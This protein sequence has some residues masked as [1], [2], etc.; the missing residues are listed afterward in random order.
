MIVTACCQSISVVVYTKHSVH[1]QSLSLVNTAFQ[2]M[3]APLGSRLH[4]L[5]HAQRLFK[6]HHHHQP[7]SV[8]ITTWKWASLF[9]CGITDLHANVN[10]SPSLCYHSKLSFFFLSFL[11]SLSLFLSLLREEVQPASGPQHWDRVTV[12]CASPW[13]VG[14][15]VGVYVR[16]CGEGGVRRWTACR[17]FL[18]CPL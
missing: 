2:F 11:L 10:W 17:V 9:L 14:E 5:Q 13:R 8:A 6:H 15:L 7:V 12:Q 1:C 16:E 18:A 4:Q 3:H